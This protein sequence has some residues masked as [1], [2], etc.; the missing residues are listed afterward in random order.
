MRNKSDLLQVVFFVYFV[1]P[2]VMLSSG[3][4]IFVEK[5]QLLL[6][7]ILFFDYLSTVKLCYDELHGTVA[8]VFVCYNRDFVITVKIYVVK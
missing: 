8:S 5:I 6:F 2:S 1:L 7:L 3:G 4:K